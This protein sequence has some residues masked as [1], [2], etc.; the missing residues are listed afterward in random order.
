MRYLTTTE[1]AAKFDVTPALVRRWKAQGRIKP[2]IEAA[3]GCLYDS[4]IRKPKDRKSGRP[5][6][7]KRN[8]G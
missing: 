4:R 6:T 2:A 3:N 7:V 1:V 5:T 8:S